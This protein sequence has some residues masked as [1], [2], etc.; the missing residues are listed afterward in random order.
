MDRR[1]HNRNVSVRRLATG[2]ETDTTSITV[3]AGGDTVISDGDTLP[4][5]DNTRDLGSQSK[6]WAN[7]YTGD[8]HLKN[9]RGNWTIVEE[10]EY[11]CVINT[12]TGKKY[13]MVLEELEE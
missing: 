12:T 8:L 1:L 13:K 6:R 9:E 3:D 7:L 4:D 5:I 2:V 10:K 11:L